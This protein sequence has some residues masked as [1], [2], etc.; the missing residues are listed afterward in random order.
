MKSF[1]RIYGTNEILY[2]SEK[3]WLPICIA[4]FIWK[5]VVRNIPFTNKNMIGSID[6][7]ATFKGV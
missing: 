3:S 4:V 5:A 6:A 1:V 7:E 2:S